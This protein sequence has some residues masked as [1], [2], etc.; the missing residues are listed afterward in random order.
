M[1]HPHEQATG[2]AT[3]PTRGWTHCP[4]RLPSVRWGYPAYA[5]MDPPA[6]EPP[7]ALAGLPRLRG[8]GP[9]ERKGSV[10][11][12]PA[13]PPT[14]GWTFFSVP[15]LNPIA[16]YPA[17]AGMDPRPMLISITPPRLPRLR[18]DGPRATCCCQRVREA[19]PPTRGWTREPASG[20]CRE[21]GYPAYA[22]MDLM[23]VGMG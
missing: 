1:A 9:S 17:Y 20:C 3:P 19:T 21:S 13:T 16:G 12:P 2:Q 18:G 11:K 15:S 7:G 4:S 8:D 22:G 5:G 10:E 6:A 23:L 14:R